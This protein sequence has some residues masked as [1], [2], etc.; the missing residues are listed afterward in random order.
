[1]KKRFILSALVVFSFLACTKQEI[2][3]SDAPQYKYTIKADIEMAKVSVDA[4]GKNTWCN[5]DAIAVFF[6]GKPVRFDLADGAGTSTGMFACEDDLRGKTINGIAVYPYSTSVALSGDQVTVNI[7]SSWAAENTPAP[8][9]ATAT[10]EGIYTFRNVA[11]IL[12]VQYSNLPPEAKTLKLTASN[13]ICGNFTL[14]NASSATMAIPST[15]NNNVVNVTIPAARP[16]GDAYVDVPVGAGSLSSI[17]AE[18]LDAWG[19]TINTTNSSSSKSFTVGHV[20]P[21]KPITLTGDRMKVEWIWDQGAL[22]TFRSSFPAIDDNGNVYVSTN[23]GALYKLDRNG[24]LLWR[25]ALNNMAGKVETS[26]TVEP[27]GSAVYMAGGQDG[28]AALYALSADGTIKWTFNDWPFTGNRNFWQTI[29][30]LDGDN[31]YVAVGSMCT[32]LTINKETGARVSYGAGVKGGAQGGLAGPGTG[33]AIGL[34]GTVSFHSNNGAF[35]WNKSLLDNPTMT[36]E[37]FGKYAL[38]SYQDLW[39]GWGGFQHDKHGVIAAKK[40][41]TLGKNVIISCNQEKYGRIDVVC[42]PATFGKDNELVRHDNSTYVYHWRHQ[43]GINDNSTQS[44]GMQDQGGIVMGHENL[45]VIVPMKY[46]AGTDYPNI[47]QAGLYSIWVGR[48]DGTD[49]GTTCWRVNLGEDNV[50]GAA[51]VDNNGHVHFATN[52]VY[53]IIEPNTASGGSYKVKARIPMKELLLASGKIGDF[54]YTGCWSSVKIAKDGRIYLNINISSTRGITCCF[55]YPGVTGPDP[56]S[57]WPQ[58]GADQYNS[59]KQ[60]L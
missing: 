59:C 9:T 38:F 5:D 32:L 43:I 24:S 48:H 53:Y 50:S 44:P 6:D 14:S 22:P 28:T 56:T 57:S 34:E 2:E 47:T 40:G 8:M 52:G 41:P 21:L 19:T 26:P 4:A 12:R 30:G 60:Q 10:E 20:K 42:Y 27:D 29:I 49:G 3:Q 1:M 58:K 35:T 23:E 11:S 18:L 7:P 37:T 13:T 55:T 51:A 36:N 45:V 25:T 15:T 46:R 31:L 17:K 54:D 33:V 39:P 16:T